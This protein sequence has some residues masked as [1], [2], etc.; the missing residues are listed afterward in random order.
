MVATYSSQLNISGCHLEGA[1]GGEMEKKILDGGLSV[2]REKINLGWP[3]RGRFKSFSVRKKERKNC[4]V[5][6]RKMVFQR[7]VQ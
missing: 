4:L 7:P 6:K 1:C 5:S 3:R 2:D